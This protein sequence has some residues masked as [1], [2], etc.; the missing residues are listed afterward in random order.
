MFSK[1]HTEGYYYKTFETYDV[2]FI[3][4]NIIRNLTSMKLKIKTVQ[5]E[6]ERLSLFLKYVDVVVN[7]INRAIKSRN[8]LI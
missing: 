6:T 3:K 8:D 1:S 5:N 2:K 4:Q 7:Q